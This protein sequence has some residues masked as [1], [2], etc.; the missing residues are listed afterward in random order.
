MACL[1]VAWHNQPG[2]PSGQKPDAPSRLKLQKFAL[3]QVLLSA[4]PVVES[5]RSSKT[6][7]RE[8]YAT[9]FRNS[10]GS[11]TER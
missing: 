11:K 8:H 4:R 5:G 2:R 1:F 10:R 9:G 7:G 3:P 6:D